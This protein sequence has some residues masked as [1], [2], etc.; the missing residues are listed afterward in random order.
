VFRLPL[1]AFADAVAPLAAFALIPIRLGCFLN[2]CCF[3]ERCSLPWAVRFPRGSWP[4]W[5][6]AANGW[7]SPDS[8]YSL[9]VHPLQLYFLVAALSTVAILLWL[10]R[11][12]PPL[13]SVYLAFCF[14]FF[15]STTGL[16]P[17]RANHLTLNQ[18]IA[19]L[20]ATVSLAAILV[21]LLGASRGGRLASL[22][23]GRP[24]LRW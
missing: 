18:W 11:L 8:P 22:P 14:L 24:I 3:G 17:L 2:G 7:L 16:E 12:R 23:R 1:G 9:P 4:Y 21:R 19:P 6:H 20:G 10:Q 15:S 5:Y 13:G